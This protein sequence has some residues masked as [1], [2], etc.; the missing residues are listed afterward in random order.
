MISGLLKD[1]LAEAVN[2]AGIPEQA[3]KAML[4]GHVQI[5]LAN[6]L[7]G[8]NAFSDAALIAMDYGR[9][10]V[11]KDDWRRIFDEAELDTVIARMLQLE[12]V[13][14]TS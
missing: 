12:R 9:D 1:V 10:R 8:S 6:S 2:T 7:L 4:F 13:H 11:I 14:H 3:V 5:A